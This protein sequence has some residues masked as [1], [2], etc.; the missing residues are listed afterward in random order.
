MARVLHVD[1]FTERAYA[2]NALAVVLVESMPEPAH[3]QRVAAWLNLSE[4][5]FLLPPT[6][7]GADYRVRIFTPRQELP[8]AG[9]PSVGAAW[10][11]IRFGLLP[12]APGARVQECG[13]GLLPL[14]IEGRG[15]AR[16]IHVQAPRAGLR[17]ALDAAATGRVR[18]ALGVAPRG[19]AQVV[20]V[21]AVWL[22]ADLDTAA[23]VRGL[24]PD[25]PAVARLTQALGCVGVGVFGREPEGAAALAVRAFCPGDGIA[26]DPVT[27]SANAAIGALLHARGQLPAARYAASQGR[28]VG[29]DGRV[30][31][32]VQPDGAV[33]IGGACV[34][35]AEGTLAL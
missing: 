22:L 2:G 21:G 9:H 27:G 25:L 15:A 24:V 14:R 12:D 17:D 23:A 10:A 1:V 26:E 19:P 13:A 6:Q 30:E 31:V 20:D 32:L 5:A 34:L 16:R 18:Q 28:E 35:C 29:R 11:A 33:W 4:T 8:F 3:M 7:P